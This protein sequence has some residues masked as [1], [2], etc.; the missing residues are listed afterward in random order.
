M[1]NK[2]SN[3]NQELSLRDELEQVSG[4]IAHLSKRA[5]DE[6]QDK[7]SEEIAHLRAAADE[8]MKRTNTRAQATLQTASAQVQEHPMSSLLGAFTAGAVVAALLSRR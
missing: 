2:V 5:V 4:M 1:A 7:V 8:L 6:G 3:G